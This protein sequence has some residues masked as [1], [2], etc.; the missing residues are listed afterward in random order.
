MYL[1]HLTSKSWTLTY[2]GSLECIYELFISVSFMNIDPAPRNLSGRYGNNYQ[3][4]KRRSTP[5]L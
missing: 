2:L 3:D 5:L 4:I 1:V